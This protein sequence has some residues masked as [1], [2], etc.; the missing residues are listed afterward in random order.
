[1][2]RPIKLHQNV[3]IQS[4]EIDCTKSDKLAHVKETTNKMGSNT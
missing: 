1:M 3:P 2:P 4:A